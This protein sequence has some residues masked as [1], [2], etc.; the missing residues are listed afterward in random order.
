MCGT[1]GDGTK[2][3]KACCQGFDDPG[4]IMK[5]QV[6]SDSIGQHRDCGGPLFLSIWLLGEH[7][8]PPWAEPVHPP[9][10]PLGKA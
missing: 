1:N 10:L 5:I 3:K 7:I 9:C 8:G 6:D 2:T 4:R